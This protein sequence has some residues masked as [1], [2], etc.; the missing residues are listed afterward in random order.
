MVGEIDSLRLAREAERRKETEER[1]RGADRLRNEVE[2]LRAEVQNS[3]EICRRE[4]EEKSKLLGKESGI[5]FHLGKLAEKSDWEKVLGEKSKVIGNLTKELL[6]F[7][8]GASERLQ[9][10]AMELVN[11]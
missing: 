7:K 1:R 4:A 2:V 9:E 5:R 8:K 6:S 11:E 10:F 3:R